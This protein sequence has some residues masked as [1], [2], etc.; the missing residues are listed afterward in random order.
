VPF[1]RASFRAR[2][3]RLSDFFDAFK[4]RFAICIGEGAPT[5][6]SANA[7][8]AA[9]VSAAITWERLTNHAL[10]PEAQCA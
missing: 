6:G 2:F 10:C 8:N 9:K 5:A 4:A 7:S 3:D 1:F